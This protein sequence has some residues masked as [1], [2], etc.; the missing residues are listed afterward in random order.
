[1]LKGLFNFRFR[2]NAAI[3]L[4]AVG[5]TVTGLAYYYKIVSTQVWSQM[6]SRVKDFGKIGTTILAPEDIK[7]LENLDTD[8]NSVPRALPPVPVTGARLGALADSE[9]TAIVRKSAF[10][11]IVQKLRRI[12]HASG[13]NP[14]YETTLPAAAT[15]EQGAQIHRIWIAGVR[16]HEHAPQFLRVLVADEFEEIDRNN[17]KRI[18][19]E[20]SIYHV[21]DVFNGRGQAGINAALAG[22]VAVSTG[23]RS[24]SSGV[25]ISGYTPI[26]NSRGKIIALLVIDFSAATEF[27]ALFDLKITGYYIIISVLLFSIIAASATSRFLLKPLENMQRAAVR[28]G[29]RDFSVRVESMSSDELADLAFA[30]N[31]MAQELGE[32]STHMEKRIAARTQEISGILESLEQGLLTVDIQGII[33]AEYSRATLAIFGLADIAHRKFSSL[34]EDEKTA[35]AVEKYLDLFF[36]GNAISDQM[37]E[38]ANPLR[39]ITYLNYRGEKRHLRFAFR[40][41]ASSGETAPQKLLVSIIDD[42]AEFSLREKI[43]LAE[44]DKRSE[45]D[46]LITLMQIPPVIL[47]NFIAQQKDILQRGKEIIGKFDAA[48]PAQFMDYAKRVH[49]LKG[50]AL[51]LGFT[52]LGEILHNLETHLQT[53]TDGG[54]FDSRYLRHEVSRCINASEATMLDRDKLIARIRALVGNTASD[55]PAVK[56]RQLTAFWT[57]QLER[58]AAVSE[59]PVTISID[60]AEGSDGIVHELHNVLVQMV[61]NTFAHGVEAPATRIAAGK[62]AELKIR[63]ATRETDRGYELIYQEDG[64]GFPQGVGENETELRGLIQNGL[65]AAAGSVT[66]EAGRGLGMEYI[67][68]R[69]A[70][71]GAK[72]LISCSRGVTT[73]RIVIPG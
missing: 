8:L 17:N 21:G 29:Q 47:E 72:A 1:M 59:T 56:I 48:E 71:L 12:R 30:M 67:A 37:L 2:L 15:I 54:A 49:A 6:M 26:K 58:K 65:T 11:L 36:H 5:A 22:E 18:D 55:D 60:F 7:H 42:T 45:F 39:E 53:K 41:I 57:N 62:R 32:Y 43:N 28:I 38:R 20:E 64:K 27:D 23:Y 70:E 61:R 24:E 40:T 10:Q 31:L 4:V 66:L 35:A 9:K 50:N 33:Q 34:F 19:P 13:K 68:A 63:I 44:A 51:Q 14:V 16:M 52:E 3:F 73:V 46:V 69:I 25:Y